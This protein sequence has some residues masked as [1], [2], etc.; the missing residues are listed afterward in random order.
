MLL[1]TLLIVFGL[2]AVTAFAALG[3]RRTH[4]PESIFLVLVGLII[5]FLPGMP[6]IALEPHLVLS[7]LCTTVN[8]FIASA[9]S[10]RANTLAAA[11]HQLIDNVNLKALFDD[12]GMINSSKVA[13]NGGKVAPTAAKTVAALPD[14][15]GSGQP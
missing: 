3:A 15:T 4:I 5:S 7:L 12:H 10:L 6:R 8:E 2:M 9:F 14:P 1:P 11:L 13:A